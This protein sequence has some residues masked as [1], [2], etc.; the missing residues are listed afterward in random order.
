[1]STQCDAGD[2]G[3]PCSRCRRLNVVCQ[4]AGQ[5]RYKF[6][7]E[8]KKF[9]SAKKLASSGNGGVTSRQK[10]SVA[11]ITRNPSN[12]ITRLTSAFVGSINP[13]MDIKYQLLWNFGDYLADVPRR[14]GVNPAL[15]VASDALVSVHTS[16]CSQGHY[17]HDPRVLAKYSK[18]LVALR[19]ALND[20]DKAYSSETLCAIMLL[21]IVQVCRQSCALVFPQPE[22][23]V[24]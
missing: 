14:L 5:Q 10:P 23:Y 15:D 1:M 16:F 12:Q 19:D 2:K 21:M 17:V 7:D 3:P 6:Q 13:T 22:S 24:S 9:V 18:A 8:S 4:G 20:P 11:Q